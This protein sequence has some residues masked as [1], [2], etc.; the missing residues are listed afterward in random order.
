MVTPKI[1]LCQTFEELS[2]QGD[3]AQAT[4]NYAQAELIWRQVLQ[5]RSN[6]AFVYNKLGYSLYRQKKYDLAVE[7]YRKSL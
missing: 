6:D 4:G 2:Q 3:A 1:G 7:A 5:V